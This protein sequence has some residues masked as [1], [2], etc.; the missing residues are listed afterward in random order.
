MAR[1][2]GPVC[3]L[4]RR[5]GE[6]LS[7]KGDRCATPKCAMERRAAPP[8][9][10]ALVRGRGRRGPRISERGLQLQEKQKARR[11]YGVLEKQFRRYFTQAKSAPG[12]TGGNMLQMLERR[13]DNVVFR[14]GF[15]D[16]RSQAR[17]VVRHGHLLVN[18]GKVNIPSFLVKPG[19]TISWKEKSKDTEL[20]KTV[21]EGIEGREVSSWLSL[22]VQNLSGQVLSLPTREEI[23]AKFDEQAIVEYYS[24]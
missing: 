18:G 12:I 22:D 19:D 20:Y 17:Q 1:Y 16:S 2:T 11:T 23:D 7:L 15:A 21:V 5:A 3:R 14:L 13:L 6:K 10:S 4:C 9:Q 8:G 24:R